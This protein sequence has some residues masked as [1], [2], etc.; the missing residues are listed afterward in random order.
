MTPPILPARIK[1]V[2]GLG[3]FIGGQILG[4]LSSTSQGVLAVGHVVTGGE[5]ELV[6]PLREPVG[7]DKRCGPRS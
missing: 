6:A 4:G 1:A 5:E 7:G 3:E 2:V